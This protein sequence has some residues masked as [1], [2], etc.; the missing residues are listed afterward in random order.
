MMA[1]VRSCARLHPWI[2]AGSAAAAGFV[3]G[4]LLL[5]SSEKP[6]ASAKPGSEANV[7][8]GCQGSKTASRRS[9][10]L[11]TAGRSVVMILRTLIQGAITTILFS[12]KQPQPET[13]LPQR[14]MD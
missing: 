8:P 6:S 3:A 11:A 12:E 4:V 13:P 14:R 2:V 5:R 7:P 9:V 1:D 10:V